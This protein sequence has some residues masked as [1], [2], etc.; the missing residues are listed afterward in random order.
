MVLPLNIKNLLMKGKLAIL[1]CLLLEF[2]SPNSIAQYIPPDSL[3]KIIAYEK[4]ETKRIDA[5]NWLSFRFYQKMDTL[6]CG[7]WAAKALS[8][9]RKMNYRNGEGFA[10][11]NMANIHFISGNVTLFREYNKKAKISLESGGDKGLLG[12]VH[13]NMALHTMHN[14]TYLESL[15]ELHIS[16]RLQ[17]E[18]G[19]PF[20]MAHNKMSFG[21]YHFLMEDYIEAEKY[22]NASIKLLAEQNE[23]TLLSYAY[24]YGGVTNSAIKKYNFALAYLDK[25]RDLFKTS[26][27][28]IWFETEYYR[29]AAMVN[30]ERADSCN[31]LRDKSAAKNYFE[32]S[33]MQLKTAIKKNTINDMDQFGLIYNN[34]GL[35]YLSWQKYANSKVNFIK[36]LEYAYITGDRKV[37]VSTY[38]GLAK[39]D[40]LN[41]DYESA[42]KNYQKHILYRDSINKA[43]SM[44]E[45]ERFKIE[46]E[47]EKILDE[48]KLLQA[49]NKLKSV[50]VYNERLYKNLAFAGIVLLVIA[51][52]Y[53]FRRYR[54]K[55]K[56][57]RDHALVMQKHAISRDLHDEVGATLSGIAMYSHM[58]KTQLKDN[59]NP[60]IKNSI[61]IILRHSNEMVSKL[62]DIVWLMNTGNDNLQQ[63]IQRLED[64]AIQ[65]AAVKKIKVKSNIKEDNYKLILPPETRRNIY[66]L[67]KEAINNAVKYSNATVFE[68]TIKDEAKGITI[69]FADNG[70]GYDLENAKRGNG[71]KN[72]A[73]RAEEINA[74][75]EYCTMAGKGTKVIV[76]LPH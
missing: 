69:V 14:Q 72:M 33:E 60:A 36:S 16:Q 71:L 26:G 3:M 66:L 23:N 76:H 67:F 48:I 75:Y 1:F 54:K 44:R 12:V 19:F 11:L 2:V 20:G 61:D 73:S 52:S 35:L 64:Y 42:L 55:K 37:L 29:C 9:S 62:N 17:Q 49:D 8:S 45:I 46:L 5:M 68:F 27:E 7:L 65:M 22:L 50:V 39:I 70:T 41:S 15:R 31:A 74:Q 28:A 25:A 10:Y 13:S 32:L 34:L 38:E 6:N 4:S 21:I 47:N 58:A 43:S 51:S 59:A 24:Y 57:E 18:S 53:G 56:N 63:L 30:L 40:S